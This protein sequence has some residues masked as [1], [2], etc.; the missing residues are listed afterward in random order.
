MDFIEKYPDKSWNWEWISINPNITIDDIESNPNKPWEW[1]WIS[2]N[3]NLTVDFIEKY[4]DK[5]W[6]WGEISKNL[7]HKH[8]RITT[9]IK[10]QSWWRMIRLRIIYRMRIKKLELHAMIKCRP[11]SGIHYQEMLDCC[12]ELE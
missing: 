11:G 3:P 1:G 6:N 5:P 4:A 9:I 7:F 8:P 12:D 2:C 10:V